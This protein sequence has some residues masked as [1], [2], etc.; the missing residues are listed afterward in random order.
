MFFIKDAYATVWKV[1]ENDTF[2]KGTIST[3]EKTQEEGKSIWSNWNVKYVGKA[4]EKALSLVERDRIKILSG[5]INTTL[6][7]KDES[8]KLYT[9]VTVF[10]FELAGDYTPNRTND[11]ESE[12]E[13]DALPFK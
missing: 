9:N 3:K 8:K 12:S 7:G 6:W 1:E 2:V 11:Q 13:E 10:D 4:K 5:K